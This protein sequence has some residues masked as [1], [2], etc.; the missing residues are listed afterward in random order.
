MSNRQLEERQEREFVER[1][2]ARLDLSLGQMEELDW[3]LD[4]N[5][6]NDG[7]VYGY[8]I[9]FRESDDVAVQ[10]LVDRLTDGQGWIQIGPNL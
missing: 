2:A 3:S 1:L 4:E 6:G 7:A 10:S 8:V 9:T 5:V